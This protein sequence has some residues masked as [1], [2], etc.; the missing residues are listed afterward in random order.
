MFE[1]LKHWALKMSIWCSKGD[2]R[3]FCKSGRSGRSTFGGVRRDGQVVKEG[4][5]LF[6]GF[7]RDSVG[8]GGTFRVKGTFSQGEKTGVWQFKSDKFK[9]KK[10]LKVTYVHGK[11]EGIYELKYVNHRF[12]ARSI[13]TDLRMQMAAGKPSGSFSAKS[14]GDRCWGS[15]DTEGR[16]H[17]TWTLQTRTQTG[18]KMRVEE[19]WNHGTFANGQEFVR[20]KTRTYDNRSQIL[21]KLYSL[22]RGGMSLEKVCDMGSSPVSLFL[23]EDK[24]KTTD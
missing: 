21:G 1:S 7:F 3:C 22:I 10:S 16:P 20:D 12:T 23:V 24:K 14:N 2:I 18:A 11:Q 8:V 4:P 6:T 5:F 17:G 15:F 9:R 19:M 13:R